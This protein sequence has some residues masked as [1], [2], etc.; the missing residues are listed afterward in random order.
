MVARMGLGLVGVGLILLLGVFSW[1]G[2]FANP[3][4]AV[5]GMVSA[6][7]LGIV[8]LVGASLVFVGWFFLSG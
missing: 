5:L 1:L 6:V 7:V 2:G 4:N 8:V 3:L